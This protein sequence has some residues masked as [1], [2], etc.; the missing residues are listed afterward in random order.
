MGSIILILPIFAFSV[1]LLATTGR[2]VFKQALASGRW[3]P[4]LT[5]VVIGL[6][7]GWLFSFRVHY[8]MGATLRLHSFPVPSLFTYLQDSTWVDSP[9]P[10]SMQLAVYFVDFVCGIALAFLPFKLAEFIRQ[11]KAEV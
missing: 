2:R 5:V 8:K 6:V 3:M 7:L 11:V 10:H 4:L 9:L 1:W